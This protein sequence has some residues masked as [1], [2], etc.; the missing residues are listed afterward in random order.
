MHELSPI[1][2]NRK[3]I[4]IHLSKVIEYGAD[5]LGFQPVGD[6]PEGIVVPPPVPG[7]DTS[8]YDDYD[9]SVR[10]NEPLEINNDSPRFVQ[11]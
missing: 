7:N 1:Y 4:I 11:F 3:S 10:P 9:E 6:L 8:D 5:N 2:R